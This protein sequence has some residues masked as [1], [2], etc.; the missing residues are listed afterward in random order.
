VALVSSRDEVQNPG[1]AHM[2]QL[3]ATFVLAA[4]MLGTPASGQAPRREIDNV[5]AFARVYG[6]VRYFYPSDAAASLDWNRFAVHGVTEVRAARDVKE[7]QATLRALFNPLGPGLEIGQ[8]L[9]TPPAPGSPDSQLVAWRYVGAGMAGTS[10]SGP[11]KAKRTHRAPLSASGDGFTTMMQ[12]VPALYLRGKTIRLRGLVRATPRE[13][14]ASAA[15]WMR[16]DRA[17]RQTG[18]F[19]NMSNRPIREPE[20][21][22]YV[23]E[24]PVAED[25][26]NLSFGVM[27]SGA[28][29]A[30]FE[31]IGLAERDAAG[32]W[33][34][35]PIKDPGF[36][37]PGTGS[38]GWTKAG[39]SNNVEITRPADKAPEGRQ[40]MRL[41]PSAPGS[42]PAATS[43]STAE[44][45]ERPPATGAHA[46]IDLGSALKARVPLALSEA[47]AIDDVTKSESLA[48]L[49]AAVASV[50]DAGNEPD[51]DT[52][53][54]DVVV[55]WNVFR[56]F[57]PYW[58][59]SR[60]DWDARLRPE[61]ERMFGANTRAAQ[62][63]ALR[64]LV[65][66]VHDGHG[67]VFDARGAGERGVLPIQLGIIDG[68]LVVTASAAP[69]DAPVGA[70]VSTMDGVPAA[71]RVSEATRLASGSP[72][73]KETRALREI[74]TCRAGAL[75]TLVIDSG[76]G[77]HTGSLR[78]DAKQPPPEK[79]PAP[80]VELTSGLWYV[81]LTRAPMRDVVPVLGKLAQATGVV[82]DV[83]GYPTDAG[84]G[85]LPYLIETSEKD[86]WMH[87]NK[88]IGPFGQSAG[89]ESFGWN[90]APTGPRVA[91][92]VVF[93]TDGR[94]ISYAESVMGYVADRKLATIVGGTTAGA[95]GNVVT[96]TVP[97]GYRIAFTGM[98]VTRHDGES[99]H[100]LV[101]IRPDMLVAPTIAGLRE[102]RD[103]VLDR[104][105]VVI[106]G[107]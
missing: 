43:A 101:G 35:I 5:A 31:A 45:F 106:R 37:G 82:F 95:N 48:A 14:A 10:A 107:Q 51:L 28:V 27:V 99:P 53:L 87:V 15:L 23:I 3:L 88:I 46:D 41:A 21:R 83:R 70:I 72:Q 44:L 78:C 11:Y 57:Y 98:R 63:D 103:E 25:A 96:F 12:S 91:G 92:K 20:W 102:G 1:E 34:P 80:V 84:V 94:A 89:W 38:E 81:D 79:R 13:A 39:T 77:P 56:H 50:K 52:R 26:T 40:F 4:T 73:W 32:G 64:Q 33:T 9:T 8:P 22:E 29:T 49:R 47:Q 65:A 100:H 16:V 60:V 66:G 7:L 59:E 54:A 69:E 58:T 19:D 2:R 85:I 61:L 105:V 76:A 18:F 93:L 68:L 6:V 17:N 30:D 74:A 67:S 90:L 62:Y 71:Q 75:V 24:G 104:A 86:R 42:N 55:A 36:E 97:G